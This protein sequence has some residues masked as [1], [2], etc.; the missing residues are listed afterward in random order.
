[1]IGYSQGTA[2]YRWNS[3]NAVVQHYMPPGSGGMVS[4]AFESWEPILRQTT[5]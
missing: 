1:M 3:E 4:L 2:S 5:D